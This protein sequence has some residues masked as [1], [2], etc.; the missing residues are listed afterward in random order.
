MERLASR[1]VKPQLM[2]HCN[3]GHID[4]FKNWVH[5]RRSF[6]TESLV[7]L[8]STN[9]ENA[10]G[11]ISAQYEGSREVSAGLGKWYLV[12]GRCPHEGVQM[13]DRPGDG[14]TSRRDKRELA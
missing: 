8:K 13:R 2:R 10:I 1:H 3:T 5:N 4:L 12:E 11:L 9:Q 14:F 6:E 7:G